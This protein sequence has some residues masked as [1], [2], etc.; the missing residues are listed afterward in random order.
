M[1]RFALL[2]MIAIAAPLAAIAGD[3]PFAKRIEYSADINYTIAGMKGDGKVFQGKNADRREMT[4]QGQRSVMIV[5]NKELLML[6]PDLNMA[7][8]MPLDADPLQEALNPGPDVKFTKLGEE[9]VN[10]EQTAKYKVDFEGGSSIIWTTDDGIVM[11][12]EAET[13]EGKLTVNTTNVKR[14]PQ[15]ASLFEL[16]SGVQIMDIGNFGQ[17]GAK[18]GVNPFAAQ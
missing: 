8:R 12:V 9:S 2:L 7:M 15:P 10:G 3:N 1:R 13:G 17:I 18:G 14:G 5:K 11:K 16:P 4:V 6:M